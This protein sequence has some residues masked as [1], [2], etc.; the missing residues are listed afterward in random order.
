VNLSLSR[1][2]LAATME[3]SFGSGAK[4]IKQCIFLA[5]ECLK[6]VPGKE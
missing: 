3:I 4:A 6:K 5:A 1:Y 2:F